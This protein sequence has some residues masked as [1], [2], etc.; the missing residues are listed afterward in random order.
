MILTIM[1]VTIPKIRDHEG[2]YT[3]GPKTKGRMALEPHGHGAS[4]P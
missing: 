1:L 2:S 3:D 4:S